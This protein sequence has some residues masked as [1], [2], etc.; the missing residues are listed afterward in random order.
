[1]DGVPPVSLS[2]RIPASRVGASLLHSLG[3]EDWVA[4]T[5][6]QFVTIA[7]NNSQDVAGLAA[8]R[9]RACVSGFR[10]AR[11][12]HRGNLPV[13]SKRA[14]WRLSPDCTHESYSQIT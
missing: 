9:G 2:G 1:M 8:A 13:N 12:D 5:P 4:E 10:R 3:L 11:W 14:C 6:E 7:K